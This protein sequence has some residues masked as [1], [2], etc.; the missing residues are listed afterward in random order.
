MV[1]EVVVAL[2]A[3]VALLLLVET[4]VLIMMEATATNDM[5]SI[6]LQVAV[7]YISLIRIILFSKTASTVMETHVEITTAKK[8][9]TMTTKK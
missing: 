5:T 1:V 9:D 3:V 4:M 2:V 6:S 8:A 7:L